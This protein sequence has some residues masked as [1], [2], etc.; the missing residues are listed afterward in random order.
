MTLQE[1]IDKLPLSI[2]HWDELDYSL[3][4]EITIEEVAVKYIATEFEF[5]EVAEEFT[6]F[7]VCNQSKAYDLSQRLE[8]VVDRALTIIENKEW[9]K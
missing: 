3:R 1:K 8:D 9:E 2:A 7:A 5:L 6:L 4:I